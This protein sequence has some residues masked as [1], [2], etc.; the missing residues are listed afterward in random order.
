M[1]IRIRCFPVADRDFFALVHE[2]TRELETADAHSPDVVELTVAL[3]RDRYPLCRISV[4][5]GLAILRDDEPVWYAFR[6]GTAAPRPGAV[7]ARSSSILGRA[8]RRMTRRPLT[9][10]TLPEP[11]P[12]ARAPI[13]TEGERATSAEPIAVAADFDP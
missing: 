1:A 11:T 10:L 3:W 8:L 5:E 2:V 4:R 13:A 7:I 12:V 9:P 6:D